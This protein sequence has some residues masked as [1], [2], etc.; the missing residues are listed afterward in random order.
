MRIWSTKIAVNQHFQYL[1]K[2]PYFKEKVKKIE[3]SAQLKDYSYTRKEHWTWCTKMV[4]TTSKLNYE[5]VIQYNTV[6][7]SRNPLF[8]IF[9]KE[10][11]AA[12]LAVKI[13]RVNGTLKLGFQLG[14][15]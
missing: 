9:Q 1:Y 7:I 14:M 13:V 11:I 15:N 10:K 4:A 3:N 2:H 8:R 5:C 6:N 12:K